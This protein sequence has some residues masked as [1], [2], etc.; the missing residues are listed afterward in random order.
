MSISEIYRE[1]IWVSLW[2]SLLFVGLIGFLSAVAVIQLFWGIPIGDKPA[3]T[4]FLLSLE[5][6]LALVFLNF[7]RLEI[8]VDSDRIEVKYGVIK[9]VIPI[10][11]IAFCEIARAKVMVYG[12]V[13]IRFGIDGSI[14]FTTSFGNAVKIIR[15]TGRPFV[16]ST[17]KPAEVL[18]LINSLIIRV[19]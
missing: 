7:S 5:V 1:R 15:K 6:F 9:K 16:F 17:N 14:A 4:S 10:R 13:G 11:E 2:V 8:D 3:P 18:K 19:V 12:G